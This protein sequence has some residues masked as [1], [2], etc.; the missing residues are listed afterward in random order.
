MFKVG[1]EGVWIDGAEGY[2][3]I[4][5]EATDD[6]YVYDIFL[7]GELRYPDYTCPKGIVEKDMRRLTKLERALR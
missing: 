6:F 5:K 2:Y 1:D 7:E 3:F 4:I